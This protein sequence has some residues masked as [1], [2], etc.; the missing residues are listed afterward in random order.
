M[1]SEF[2]PL[3]AYN[4]IAIEIT[5]FFT[6]VTVDPDD[7]D[8]VAD[9]EECIDSIVNHANQVLDEEGE[10]EHV[11]DKEPMDEAVENSEVPEGDGNEGELNIHFDIYFCMKLLKT[12]HNNRFVYQT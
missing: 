4:F 2:Q 8:N 1:Q 6:P 11:E 5:Y 12:D 10:E 7:P 3:Q 9:V